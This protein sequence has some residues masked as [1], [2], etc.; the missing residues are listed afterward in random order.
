MSPRS[1]QYR[2]EIP[3]EK[4]TWR[5]FQNQTLAITEFSFFFFFLLVATLYFSSKHEN[6][7][8]NVFFEGGIYFV[9]GKQLFETVTMFISI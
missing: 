4:L 9:N 2:W 6:F 8:K 3:Q 5:N 1:T 7:F